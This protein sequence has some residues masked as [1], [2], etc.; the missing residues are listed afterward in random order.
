MLFPGD[1]VEEIATG[2]V[3]SLGEVGTVGQPVK[4]WFVKFLDGQPPIQKEF[5]EIGDLRLADRS[6]AQDQ[7]RLIPQ[8]PIV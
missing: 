5:T 2:R 1:I 8:N 7:P 4:R 3:G 6:G